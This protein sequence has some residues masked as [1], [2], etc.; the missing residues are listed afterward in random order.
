MNIDSYNFITGTN[1]VFIML[2]IFLIVFNLM[3]IPSKK[4]NKKGKG[5]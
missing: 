1:T 5:K 4:N 2:V 3:L